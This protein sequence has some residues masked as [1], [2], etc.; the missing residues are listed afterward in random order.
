LSAGQ[1]TTASCTVYNQG[2]AVASASNLKYYLSS[3][4][5]YGT[6]D[7][8]LATDAIGSLAISGS[9]AVSEVLTIPSGTAAGT[10][11]IVFVADADAQV[12]E[13]NES[14]NQAFVSITVQATAQGCNSTT[15]YPSTTLTPT[16]SWKTQ[17]SIYAGE[18]TAFNVTSGRIYH[19]SYCTADGAS[20]SYDSELTLRKKSDDSFLAYSD[21]YCG[22]DAKI[23][24]T[25]TF[26]GVVKLVTTVYSCGSNSTSTKLRYRYTTAKEAEG[27]TPDE[28]TDY[29]VYPNPTTGLIHVEAMNGFTGVNH[30]AVYDIMGKEIR[31]IS[32]PDKTDSVYSFDLTGEPGGYY[33]IKIVGANSLKQFKV[34]LNK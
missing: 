20:A 29:Q 16:T 10:W 18:Y 32:I 5:T 2:T 14:N 34:V 31:K 27:F 25:A 13:S 19:F 28:A 23:I 6:G 1:T 7:T 24:W 15:Q 26:T 8:Y 17:N 22:D 33:T 4:N 9:S 30:I 21:D 11:Y 12:T 3:D